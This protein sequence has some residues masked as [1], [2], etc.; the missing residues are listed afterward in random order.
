VSGRQ[1]ESLRVSRLRWRALVRELARRG[2]GERESGAF[3]LARVGDER[4]R[5]AECVYFDD[6]DPDA[7][8]GA[9][10]IRGEK[11]VRLWAIC[12]ERGMRV[13]ADVHTHPGS[14]VR[15]STI[16]ASNPM[17]A[18]RGHIA[19][20]LPHFAQRGA[21]PKRAGVHVYAGDRSWR[22]AY[23]PDAAELL[24]RTWFWR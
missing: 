11:F 4:R 1:A 9:I 7:L 13:I 12:K 15:Q 10:S 6:I 22:S 17:I 24:R 18:R 2:H 21:T 14:G 20:I 8:N 3:L 5:V 23:G 19:I 16:D